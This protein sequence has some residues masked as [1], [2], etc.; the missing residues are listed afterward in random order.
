MGLKKSLFYSKPWQS[1]AELRG[2]MDASQC[3]DSC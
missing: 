2:G 1:C 3:K